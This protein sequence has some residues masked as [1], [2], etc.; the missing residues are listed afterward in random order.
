MPKYLSGSEI[1]SQYGIS[2]S[3]LHRWAERGRINVVRTPGSKRLYSSTDIQSIFKTSP[4]KP[5]YA[6][7]ECLRISK[8][9]LQRRIDTLRQLYPVHEL[10]SDIG[11]GLIFNEKV[12]SP[13]WSEYCEALSKKFVSYT[14]TDYAVLDTKLS[15][16]S[17]SIAEPSSSWFTMTEP[18][19]KMLTSCPKASY[20]PLQSLWRDITDNALR[21][22][23]R[24]E[25]DYARRRHRSRFSTAGS[26]P[27]G[28]HTTSASM[29]LKLEQVVIG[30]HF[31]QCVNSTLFT[32]TRWVW[33][34]LTIFET[35]LWTICWKF[36]GPI[37]LQNVNSSV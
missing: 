19:L 16:S 34:R 21:A 22:S 11:L 25:F 29:R 31:A 1:K 13:F 37:S 20:Q 17:A 2:T 14:E 6:T 8:R 12:S 15:S 24:V 4:R 28:G 23:R 9:D 3:A 5:K 7:L 33:R 30:K 35:K 26:T 10:L 18:R 36:T 27:R 32:D